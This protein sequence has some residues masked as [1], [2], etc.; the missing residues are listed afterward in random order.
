M[1]S[2][3]KTIGFSGYKSFSKEISDDLISFFGS[4]VLDDED[5][6]SILEMSNN[7]KN[8]KNKIDTKNLFIF[9]LHLQELPIHLEVRLD[10]HFQQE[11]LLPKFFHILQLL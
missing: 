7:D 6:V 8:K 10:F 11:I 1:E 4:D 5:L 3:I 9:T 2:V